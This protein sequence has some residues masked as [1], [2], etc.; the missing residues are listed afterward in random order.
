MASDRRRSRTGLAVLVLVAL[1]LV[2]IDYR[3]GSGGIVAA[4]Q[5]GFT[6]VFAPVQEGFATTV[7]PIG[8]FFGS[9]AEL[10]SLRDQ[11][12]AM[13]EELE[14]LREQRVSM[15][16]IQRENSELRGLLE[17]RERLGFTTTGAQ[18]IA[19]PATVFDNTLLIDIGADSG[20]APGMAVINSDG[21]VGKLV[22]VTRRNARVQLLTSPEATYAA[23]IADSGEDGLLSGRGSRPFQLEI[24]DPE[25]EI[26]PG[27]E[28]VTH[29]FQG[30]SI[31][32]GIPVGVVEA[33]VDQEASPRFLAVRPYVDFT[34]LSTV[35]V[36]LDAPLQ[37][38]TLPDD[39]LV[40]DGTAPRP[41]PPAST[42]EDEDAEDAEDDG[43]QA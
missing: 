17:M 22:Q 43:D 40:D 28:V 6:T 29:A 4:V 23:R 9:I 5:R 16:D 30:T 42:E 2:T 8:N 27:A 13:E 14:R 25:A 11:N 38:T 3:Q 7:R 10:G 35:Q 37:P 24:F 31:P 12:A 1:V 19:Q 32:D 39:E 34:R 21:L 18:V 15:A 33:Q 41:P 36:V 26:E 20:V